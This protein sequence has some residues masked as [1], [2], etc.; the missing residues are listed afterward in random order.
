MSIT[1]LP[2]DLPQLD[3]LAREPSHLDGMPVAAGALPA[4]IHSRGRRAGTARGQAPALALALRVHGESVE[5]DRGNRRLQGSPVAG[6]VEIGYGIAEQRRGRGFATAA[7]RELLLA[8]FAAPGVVEVYAE[9]AAENVS[10]RRVVEKAGFRHLGRRA[11]NDDGIV[12]QWV[13]CK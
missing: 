9:T 5:P 6:R 13:R 11:T 1:L 7:V 4:R 2:L 10:S 12:D 8:A 3:S